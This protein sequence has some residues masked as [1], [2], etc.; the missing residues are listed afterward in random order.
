[1]TDPFGR[2]RR[3]LRELKRR[4][5]YRVAAV[6]AAVAFV[7]VQ[8]ANLVFPALNIPSWAYSLVVVLALLGFPLA[9][10]LAWAFEVTP[11]GVRRTPE[12]EHAEE[13][14]SDGGKRLSTGYG[15]LVGL[16]LVAAAV[17]GG[18]YLTGSGST[19]ISDRSVAVLP[20]ETLGDSASST[21]TEGLHSDLLTRLQRI[22]E[23]T[24]IARPS[25]MRYER[26]DEPLSQ[27]A[28]ELGA[29]WIVSAT[30][31][32]AGD[33]VRVQ[34]RLIDPRSGAERWSD[35]YRRQLSADEV[36]AVS[37][38][39]TQDIANALKA[40]LAAGERRRL[41]GRPTG[42]LDAYRLYV[43][44]RRQF[45]RRSRA[46]PSCVEDAVKLFR[47]AIERDS[48]FALA[49][50]GLADA[51]AVYPSDAPYSLVTPGVSQEYAARRALRL[52]AD[53]AEAHASMGH[54]HLRNMDAPAARRELQRAI[55]LKPS[56][57]EAHHWLGELY[58]KI[59]R[60]EQALEHLEL[61]VELNPQ[62]ARARHWLY[63]AY[64]ATGQAKRSLQEARR[65]QEMGLEQVGAA[66]GEI[67]AL[68]RLGRLQEARRVAEEQL[69][70]LD[71]GS[72]EQLWVWSY[73]PQIS[74]LQGDTAK[75]RRE[76]DR[77][78]NEFS[79][80]LE[81][82]PLWLGRIYAA[83]GEA[84]R[85]FGA[86]ERLRRDDW[87]DIGPN[88]ALHYG[89]NIDLTRLRDDPRYQELIREANRA[90][91]LNSDG[92]FPRGK[93]DQPSD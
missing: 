18:W 80:Q 31:Q 3:F 84:D 63:D 71:D 54:F 43:Q 93:Q 49:W 64:L 83:L 29:R 42:D 15:V 90:W 22:S 52:D 91:G 28:N 26:T 74:V 59:G 51:A 39:I 10:V 92:S 14:S 53:L 13:R 89:V 35:S 75:A 88:A 46:C 50:T 1:M 68:K 70:K 21:F 17:T 48:S 67:R 85:A 81:H 65:Q 16:G 25:V 45:A 78:R 62:H 24:V 86:L 6:Y 44:G 41:E 9:L 61:A 57:W 19:S 4:K 34:P 55:D 11:E 66:Q 33:Q 47:R 36:F 40:E 37:Q 32:S 5:V 12:A 2:L 8:A 82:H 56:Y 69:A 23:L 38:E 76:F 72:Q 60:A 87:G 27:V 58:L 20:F 73:L 30:V 77:I 79:S 7:I